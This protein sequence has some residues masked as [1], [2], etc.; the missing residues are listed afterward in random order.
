MG[1]RVTHVAASGVTGGDHCRVH[2]AHTGTDGRVLA[3]RRWWC[4]VEAAWIARANCHAWW[5]EEEE[6]GT[7]E[8]KV[9]EGGEEKEGRGEGERERRRA[10]VK[11][12][13]CKTSEWSSFCFW[14]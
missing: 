1:R 5:G 3:N 14:D 10:R 6:G 4:I 12:K 2:A 11:R 13:C 9:A 8:E 7:A